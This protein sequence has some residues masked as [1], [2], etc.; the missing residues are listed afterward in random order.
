MKGYDGS[1]LSFTVKEFDPERLYNIT[2]PIR[3]WGL[4]G[5]RV[6]SLDIFCAEISAGKS[7]RL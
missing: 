5:G 4:G 1:E 6:F 3:S 2:L 7:Q